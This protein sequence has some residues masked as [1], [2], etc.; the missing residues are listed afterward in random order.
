MKLNTREIINDAIRHRENQEISFTKRCGRGVLLDIAE[1]TG[2]AYATLLT[3][4]NGKSEANFV[5]L[6][7]VMNV[8][9]LDF[10]IKKR[11]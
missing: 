6:R 8:C 9:G 2:I 3:W 11:L 7:K 10:E 4:R 1:E 5:K